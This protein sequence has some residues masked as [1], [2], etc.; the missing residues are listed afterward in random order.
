[1]PHPERAN[2]PRATRVGEVEDRLVGREAEAVRLVRIGY[3]RRQLFGSWIQSVDGIA[4]RSPLPTTEAMR[5]R[6]KPDR[7]IGVNHYVIRRA[8]PCAHVLLRQRHNAPVRLR[9]RDTT[10]VLRRNEPSFEIERV[11]VRRAARRPE[12]LHSTARVPALHLVR[13]DI[14][15]D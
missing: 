1:R 10:I 2:V 12:G 13:P 6:G 8:E 5:W 7:T 3:H 14:A 15:E 9:P 4:G 11:P